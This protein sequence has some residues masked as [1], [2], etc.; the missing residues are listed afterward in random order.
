MCGIAASKVAMKNHIC[1][2]HGSGEEMCYL[3]KA[4]GAYDKDYWLFFTVALDGT[5]N[6][7]DNFLRGIWCECCGHMSAFRKGGCEIGKSKSLSAFSVGDKLMYEYDFGST[8]EVLITIVSEISHTKQRE[9]IQPL[10]L[11]PNEA[12]PPNIF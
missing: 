10:D 8:T 9:E 2:E 1:K 3:V 6:A 11:R 12:F 4:E 5:L 7:V